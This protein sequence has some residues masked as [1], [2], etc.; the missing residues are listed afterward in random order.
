MGFSWSLWIAQESN[1]SK[2]VE[3][4][5]PASAKINAHSQEN[6]FVHHPLRF[7]VYADNIA[8]LGRDKKLVD[9]AMEKVIAVLNVCGLLTHEH[10][11]AEPECKLL[12]LQIDGKRKDICMTGKRYWRIKWAIEWVLRKKKVKGRILERD[13]TCFSALL[14]S[15]ALSVTHA[16]YKFCRKHYDTPAHLW[17]SVR[18]ELETMFGLLPTLR[19]SLV[20][21]W[22]PEF[23]GP[24]RVRVGMGL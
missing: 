17:Y 4:G 10:T 23:M 6:T 14:S 9:A 3:A 15:N 5:L 16:I 22:Q 21:R 1:R 8:M 12:G 2:V 24:T 20:R 11:T 13:T 7:V 18:R 19:V